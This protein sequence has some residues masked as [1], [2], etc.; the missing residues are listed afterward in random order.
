[1]YEEIRI[2]NA[3][4]DMKTLMMYCIMCKVGLLSQTWP[5][6]TTHIG[7]IC[8]L[9]ISINLVVGLIRFGGNEIQMILL[10][11]W[12]ILVYNVQPVCLL[13]TVFQSFDMDRLMLVGPKLSV[14]FSS[15]RTGKLQYEFVRRTSPLVDSFVFLQCCSL[16][17]SLQLNRNCSNDRVVLV[18]SRPIKLWSS[19]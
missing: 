11:C 9:I 10:A 19:N 15:F 18:L 14:K 4:E 1:M 3:I 13:L 12:F 5:T 2:K 6:L 17:R 8:C 7:S 16:H